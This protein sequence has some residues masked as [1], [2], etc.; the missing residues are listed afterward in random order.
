MAGGAPTI[1]LQGRRGKEDTEKQ[2]KERA[3]VHSKS[4]LPYNEK[5][6]CGRIYK[7]T[8]EKTIIITGT[9]TT[10]SKRA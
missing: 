7:K 6:M 2:R 4:F 8:N 9:L 1:L 3:F 10:K 5:K